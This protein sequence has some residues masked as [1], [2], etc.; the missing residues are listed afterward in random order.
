[1]CREFS[2][3]ILKPSY[4]LQE[5]STFLSKT[6]DFF[7]E[8]QTINV[9]NFKDDV[10]SDDKQKDLFD[11]YKKGFETDRAVLILNQFDVSEIVLKK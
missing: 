2:D 1:L 3:D 6:I 10:F 7:K 9:E 8:N 11:D 5:K 4:G